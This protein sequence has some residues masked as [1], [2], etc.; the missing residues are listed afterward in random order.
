MGPADPVALSVVYA[1]GLKFG[2]DRFALDK[3]GDGLQPHGL[4][5]ITDGFYYGVINLVVQQIPD[6]ASVDLDVVDRQVLQVGEGRHAAAEISE[7]ETAAR[8]LQFGDQSG[9]FTQLD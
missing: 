3:C 7:G 6:E 5:D 9:R 4:P 2:H 1:H 8:F